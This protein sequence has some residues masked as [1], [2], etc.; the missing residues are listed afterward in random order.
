M[1]NQNK[2]MGSVFGIHI[3][4]PLCSAV[5]IAYERGTEAADF[6]TCCYQKWVF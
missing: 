1:H 2:L 5:I 6:H 4:S 3:I